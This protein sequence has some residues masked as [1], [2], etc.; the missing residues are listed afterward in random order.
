MQVWRAAAAETRIEGPGALRRVLIPRFGS[1][2]CLGVGPLRAVHLLSLADGA[3]LPARRLANLS[4]LR[5][6]W[7]ASGAAWWWR[8]DC[9]AGVELPAWTAPVAL[10]GVEMWVQSRRSN[11]PARAHAEAGRLASAGVLARPGEVGW[12]ADVTLEVHPAGVGLAGSAALWWQL[13]A[14][15]ARAGGQDWTPGDGGS[16]SA[17]TALTLDAEA[18]VLAVRGG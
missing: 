16:P 8:Q 1:D 14:G 12:D 7:S 15:S 10:D 4:V 3:T 6:C 13:L 5:L 2:G 18:C 9:G 11:G 17:D